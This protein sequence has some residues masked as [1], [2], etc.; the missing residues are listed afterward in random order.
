M[1]NAQTTLRFEHLLATPASVA[2][3]TAAPPTAPPHTVRFTLPRPATAKNGAHVSRYVLQIERSGPDDGHVLRAW[4]D[5]MPVPDFDIAFASHMRDYL[6]YDPFTPKEVRI[7][8]AAGIGTILHEG[9]GTMLT[10][11]YDDGSA[12]GIAR[13]LY[14][15][16]QALDANLN[17]LRQQLN[18]GLHVYVIGIDGRIHSLV[19]EM[20]ERDG[21]DGGPR[22]VVVRGRR[23]GDADVAAAAAAIAAADTDNVGPSTPA[24]RARTK[25]T[26]EQG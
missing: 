20:D 23:V 1:G 10:L 18:V 16:W 6:V 17:T 2:A 12:F 5:D 22:V 19:E 15:H 25:P 11:A 9:S 21:P 8:R 14:M 24:K 26:L 3:A 4:S 13:P 7:E